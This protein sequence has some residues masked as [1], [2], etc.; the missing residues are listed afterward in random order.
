MCAYAEIST[1]HLMYI[2]RFGVRPGRMFCWT[3]GIVLL[4]YLGGLHVLFVL[5][6]PVKNHDLATMLVSQTYM[7]NFQLGMGT[8][9]DLD[10]ADFA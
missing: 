4:V 8:F 5:C 1:V 3:L 9:I 6:L 2:T 7:S 10:F